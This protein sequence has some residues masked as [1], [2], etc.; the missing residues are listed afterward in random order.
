MRNIDEIMNELTLEEKVSLLCGKGNWFTSDCN[1]K[2]PSIMMTDGPHGIRK[3]T[4]DVALEVNNSVPATCFPTASAVASGWDPELG[5]LMGKTIAHEAKKEQISIVLGCGINMKRSPLCGRNF[6]YFSED[7]Y[8]AGK[9]AT[10]YVQGMQGEG[11]GTSVKHFAANNQ[12]TRRQSS[13]SQIDER[14]LQEIY[15]RAFE[16]VV[17][18]AQPTTLMASYNRINGSYGCSNSHTLKELLRDKWGFKGAVM[19][20]W[21]ATMNA[22]ECHRNGLTLEMPSSGGYHDKII[23]EA[24]KS[25][26]YTEAELDDNVREVLEKLSSMSDKVEKNFEVDYD[27]HHEIARHIED[28]CAVLLKNNNV[29]PVSKDKKLIVIGEMAE[30]MRFQGGGSSHINVTKCVSA[31]DALKAAGYDVTYLQG[32]NAEKSVT[33]EELHCEVIEYIK[34]NADLENAVILF[35]TGLNDATESEG[36][37]RKNLLIPANQTA[38]LK[39]VADNTSLPIAAVTFGGAPMDYSWDEKADAILHMYLG[40]QAVGESVADLVSGDIAPSGRLAETIPL[41]IEDTPAYRYFG[42]PQDD[43]EYRESIFIGYRYYETYD[44]P[45]KYPFGYGLT[46]TQFEYSDI[47]IEKESF[48]GGEIKVTCKI[49]N[50]GN[51]EGSEVVQLYVLSPEDN[52][53]RAA[54][55][56]KAFSKVKLAPGEEKLVEFTLDDRSFA[57]YCD[58]TK[59]FEMITGEYGIGIGASVRD[60]RLNGSI[61]IEGREYFRNDRELFPEYFADNGHGMEISAEEFERL[62]GRPLSNLRGR[63]R[64]EYDL[65]CTFGDVANASIFG[66]IVR[67][68]VMSIVNNMFS[69]VSEDDPARKM[70]IMCI[71]EGALE[72][73]ISIAGGQISPKLVDILLLFANKKY[74]KGIGRAFKK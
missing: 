71:E 61:R 45:V 43:V 35:F 38:L 50:T 17:R 58:D 51:R 4:S 36:F 47:K 6:E 41:S 20:D 33:N 70:A 55:E 10:A 21:G 44:V 25:G 65:T 64:G 22:I 52:I 40:G 19:S 34:E 49:K 12:E 8:L 26:E 14:A 46:Y 62:L 5:R 30:H 67:K 18:D 23:L 27:R 74:C 31:L 15:L 63:K 72:S 37:D 29:L 7:P 73:L 56:L 11:V 39:D 28:N 48:N 1:G 54:K 2:V 60:I 68:V 59:E 66:R 13:N 16:M 3:M 69:D 42:L 53:I 32:Y 9:I 24:L 57:I